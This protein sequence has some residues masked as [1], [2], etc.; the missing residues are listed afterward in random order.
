MDIYSL[1]KFGILGVRSLAIASRA[2]QF[3]K[4]VNSN[5]LEPN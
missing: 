4:G 1:L 3:L 2:R 5:E